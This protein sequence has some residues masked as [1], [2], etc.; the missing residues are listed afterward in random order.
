MLANIIP[1]IV[2]GLQGQMN[3]CTH[4][5]LSPEVIWYRPVTVGD[6]DVAP[7]TGEGEAAGDLMAP[8]A[9]EVEVAPGAGNVDVAAALT[10]G[11][12]LAPF[13]AGDALEA[14]F[15]FCMAM[16]AG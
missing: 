9:G 7:A 4:V 12:L 6:A 3:V 2:R 13:A 14:E 8:V 16:P 11:E 15:G 10:A 5:H 1:F